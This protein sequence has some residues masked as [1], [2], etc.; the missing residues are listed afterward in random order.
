MHETEARL[1]TDRI[2]EVAAIADVLRPYGV[3]THLSVSFAAPVVLG[4]LPTADPLDEAVRGWW[5]E[6]TGAVYAAIPTSAG[7]W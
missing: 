2:G 1:L 4:G 6:A 7:T 5:A 3:R